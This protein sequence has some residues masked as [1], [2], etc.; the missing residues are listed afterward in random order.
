MR[1]AD[2]DDWVTPTTSRDGR[3][4][5]GLNGDILVWNPVTRRRHELSS[6][7][8]TGRRVDA[9]PAARA[10]R[11][12]RLAETALPSRD[13]GR[14]AATVDRRWH[15]PAAHPDAV[16]AQGTPR[17]GERDRVAEGADG[18][19]RPPQHSRHPVI[20][21]RRPAIGDL[22]AQSLSGSY[23]AALVHPNVDEL[24][25]AALASVAVPRSVMCARGPYH[26]RNPRSVAPG[27]MVVHRRNA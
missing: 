3:P 14:H 7:G 12:A 23:P 19:V 9:A 2:Y 5:H 8:G 25:S 22:P 16:A 21:S 26:M 18:H 17:R 10:H 24:R 1:A 27:H 15:R 20:D 6:M 13:R 4:T 11:S